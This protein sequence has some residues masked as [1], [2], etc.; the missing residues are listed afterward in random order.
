MKRLLSVLLVVLLVFA[1]IPVIAE[2][3]VPIVMDD[4]DLLTPEEEE[5]LL[6]A[7]SPLCDRCCVIF[8]TTDEEDSRDE[9]TKAR[10]FL[11]GQI[12]DADGLIFMIDM[13]NRYIEIWSTGNIA[14]F[15]T[16]EDAS[17]ITAETSSY[18]T[19]SDYLG[20]AKETFAAILAE[21]SPV[22][23]GT[24]EADRSLYLREMRKELSKAKDMVESLGQTAGSGSIQIAAEIR[25][26]IYALEI[27]NSLCMEETGDGIVD[28][29]QIA[30]LLNLTDEYILSLTTGEIS[31][32]Y[33]TSLMQELK[34]MELV[35]RFYGLG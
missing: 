23:E 15:V 5:E 21:F 10:D 33:L 16:A 27:I 1:A 34:E 18:A 19:N 11:M 30:E 3:V 20:C 26:H 25:S 8:W 22:E 35:L 32:V 24:E 7:M 6:Q 29:S 12:G 31:A 14:Q 4:A 28:G 13:Y 9:E 2:E 17:R